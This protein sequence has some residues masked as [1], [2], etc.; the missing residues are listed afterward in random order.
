M[1][2]TRQPVVRAARRSR[3]GLFVLLLAL[4]GCARTAATGDDP[5]P[6][7]AG[8]KPAAT[9]VKAEN[10]GK[11]E[12]PAADKPAGR[13]QIEQVEEDRELVQLIGKLGLFGEAVHE[14]WVFRY[15]GGF[16][17]A[18]LETDYE[19]KPTVGELVPEDWKGLLARDESLKSG[20]TN[21]FRK[22]GYIILAAMKRLTLVQALAPYQAHLGG[23]MAAA[24]VSPLHALVPL[25]LEVKQQRA[26]RLFLSASP[27]PKVPGTGFNSWEE[28]L[29]ML[30]GPFISQAPNEEDFHVGGG[31][32]LTPGKELTLLDRQRGYSRIRLKVRFLGDGEVSKYVG[33]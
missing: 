10:K 2:L 25:H 18:R 16:L 14:A 17:E 33:Q 6:A 21:A 8:E 32:D 31:K 9:P 27:P 13:Y 22:R 19:G 1:E 30:Q 12:K 11:E 7:D 28:Q 4:A 3:L 20:N 15:Q 5:T 26:Y 23:L 29:L 24:P